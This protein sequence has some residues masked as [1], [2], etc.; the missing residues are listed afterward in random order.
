MP[1]I[2][3]WSHQVPKPWKSTSD[4]A[5]TSPGLFQNNIV[6]VK[7]PTIGGRPLMSSTMATT[8]DNDRNLDEDTPTVTG[9]MIAEPP[10]WSRLKIIYSFEYNGK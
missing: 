1:Q 7:S 5:A 6:D 8:Y 9:V 2:T 4:I 10:V 3:L